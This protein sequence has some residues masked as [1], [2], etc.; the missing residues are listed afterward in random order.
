M[1][2]ISTC[3]TSPMSVGMGCIRPWE[4]AM[5]RTESSDTMTS[6]VTIVTGPMVSF[7][8]YAATCDAD[9]MAVHDN[10][11]NLRPSVCIMADAISSGV[12]LSVLTNAVVNRSRLERE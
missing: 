9:R 10:S 1:T 11:Y 8:E 2:K 5:S 6:C 12:H 4:A 3:S 7:L